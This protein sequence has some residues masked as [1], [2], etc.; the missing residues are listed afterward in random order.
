MEDAF[1]KYGALTEFPL[2]LP[3]LSPSPSFVT[4]SCRLAE[5][6]PES[7]MRHVV[8]TVT[9]YICPFR[10]DI[11][12]FSK[13][14]LSCALLPDTG[15]ELQTI[16]LNLPS[17]APVRL[18]SVTGDRETSSLHRDHP[19]S[20]DGTRKSKPETHTFC[21]RTNAMTSDLYFQV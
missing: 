3:A 16:F 13:R 7:G 5:Y 19:L 9:C 10:S 20:R 21:S 17:L 12:D 8:F 14:A 15:N 4:N 1:M 11:C 2:L 18:I 6:S